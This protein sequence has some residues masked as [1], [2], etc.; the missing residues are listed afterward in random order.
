MQWWRNG[1]LQTTF[2]TFLH[3]T[4]VRSHAE[5]P[6]VLGRHNMVRIIEGVSNWQQLAATGTRPLA[7]LTP[8]PALLMSQIPSNISALMVAKYINLP[9][10]KDTNNKRCVETRME[11]LTKSKCRHYTYSEMWLREGNR[12]NNT[13][14]Q[15]TIEM[16]KNCFLWPILSKKLGLFQVGMQQF[17]SWR[18]LVRT[19]FLHMVL[20]SSRSWQLLSPRIP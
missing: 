13:H 2:I 18:Q 11:K 9:Q 6:W 20:F 19:I 17:S 16:F 7:H 3:T 1:N 5:Y 14:W 12:H 8:L 15:E 10:V 4:P